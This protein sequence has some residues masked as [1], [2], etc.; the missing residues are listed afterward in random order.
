MH[1]VD[2]LTQQSMLYFLWI[3]TFLPTQQCGCVSS[4]IYCNTISVF[5]QGDK[6]TSWYIIWKGSVNVITHGKVNST[7]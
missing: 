5:R 6:G 4:A 1:T 2:D 7:G 3:S